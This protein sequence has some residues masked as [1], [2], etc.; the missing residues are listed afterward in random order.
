MGTSSIEETPIVAQV[1][2]KPSLIDPLINFLDK[3][4]L[5]L[6]KGKLEGSGNKSYGMSS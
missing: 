6:M 3:G 1:E 4:E 5:Q 2:H